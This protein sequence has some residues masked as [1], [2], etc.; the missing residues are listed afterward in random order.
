MPPTARNLLKSGKKEGRNQKEGKIEKRGK[1]WGKEEKSERKGKNLEGYF[2]LPL[3]TDMDG[4]ATE[5]ISPF[6]I[7]HKIQRFVNFLST[8]H[9][10]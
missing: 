10:M 3:L 9:A 6:Q 1:N 2:T 4:Y 5:C 7:Q 8:L